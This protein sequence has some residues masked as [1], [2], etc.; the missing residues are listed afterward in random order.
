MPTYVYKREDGSTFEVV[1]PITQKP[2]DVCPTTGQRVKVVPQAAN[3]VFR[4]A[5][6]ARDG[7]SKTNR[8]SS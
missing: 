7:Y 1:H 3:T 6:W 5:G 4:G 2:L 8:S